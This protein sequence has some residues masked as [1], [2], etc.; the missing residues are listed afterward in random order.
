MD[1]VLAFAKINLY[2]RVDGRRPDGYH[3]ITNVM[4]LISL[5]DTIQLS[6]SREFHIDLAV[7]QELPNAELI[8]TDTGNSVVRA[9]LALGW[10]GAKVV[11]R[12]RIPPGAGLGGESSD[13]AA[14]IKLG[15][16]VS[17]VSAEDLRAITPHLGSDVSFF[18]AG[19]PAALV[20]GTGEQVRPIPAFPELPIVIAMPRKGLLTSIVYRQ[21]DAM[22]QSQSSPSPDA[23]LEAVASRDLQKLVQAIY[24][25]LQAPAEALLP[26]I[27]YIRT[28]MTKHGALGAWVTGSGSAVFGIAPSPGEA[29]LIRQKLSRE[30]FVGWC[31]VCRTIG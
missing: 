20:T 15:A 30:E 26:E 28:A 18:V 24:N 31:C 3:Y 7:D 25:D 12:K 14:A 11:L 17:N 6:P 4:H 1:E 27:R 16:A 9:L 19:H 13:A 21:F 23:L 10:Q 5:H 2:L 8:P 22:V 29:E